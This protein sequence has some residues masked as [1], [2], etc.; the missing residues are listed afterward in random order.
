MSKTR[1]KFTSY[2]KTFFKDL[3]PVI[4]GILIALGINNWNENRKESNYMKQISLSID[5][6]LSETNDNI[7]E[8]LIIQESFIDTLHFYMQNEKTSLLEITNK[9]NGFHL[10]T[11]KI[12]SLKALSNVKIELMEYDKISA[13]ASIEEQS[14]ILK[15]KSERLANFLYPNLK[16]TDKEK[17]EF[18]KL[19]IL[20]IT[21]TEKALQYE[22][23]KILSSNP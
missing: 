23:Q 5:K 21:G 8:N 1:K 13:L 16:E 20:D 11:I 12:N 4:V 2:L 10:P 22:I 9:L 6:E 14:A 15:T 18:M 19:L 3:I 17:K 7:T